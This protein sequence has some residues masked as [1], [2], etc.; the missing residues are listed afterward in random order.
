KKGAWEH[1]SRVEIE[2]SDLRI[3]SDIDQPPETVDEII[4]IVGDHYKAALAEGYQD[5]QDD[6]LDS[7]EEEIVS[8]SRS[9]EDQA[10]WKANPHG[11]ISMS[12]N[13]LRHYTEAVTGRTLP[14]HFIDDDGDDDELPP[15]PPPA[16]PCPYKRDKDGVHRLVAE[17]LPALKR[18]TAAD[19]GAAPKAK[20]APDSLKKLRTGDKVVNVDMSSSAEARAKKGSS[21][22]VDVEMEETAGTSSSSANPTK[23]KPMPKPSSVPKAAASRTAAPGRDA[24]KLVPAGGTPIRTTMPANQVPGAAVIGW[25]DQEQFF[26]SKRV[27]GLLRGHNHANRRD[28]I[29]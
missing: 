10:R 23:A 14:L 25:Y 5:P 4:E 1:V 16:E 11:A 19:L 27:S 21:E 22:V 8:I 3:R 2:E 20:A 17:E 26:V 7:D 9:S 15:P 24:P 28:R 13:A 29:P 18:K 6:A 12:S